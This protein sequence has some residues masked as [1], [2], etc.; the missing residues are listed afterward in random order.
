M[1]T[2]TKTHW[3]W[4]VSFAVL[5]LYAVYQRNLANENFD[6]YDR[7]DANYRTAFDKLKLTEELADECRVNLDHYEDDCKCFC[8]KNR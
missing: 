4:K 6:K 2:K 1:E 7:A 5:A 3:I 8:P